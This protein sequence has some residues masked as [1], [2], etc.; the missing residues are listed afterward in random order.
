L[1]CLLRFLPE[2]ALP[3]VAAP[4]EGE[5]DDRP[6]LVSGRGLVEHVKQHASVR[7]A[8]PEGAQ[9]ETEGVSDEAGERRL[10]EL[11]DLGR[12]G[13]RYRWERGVV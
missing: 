10:R 9:R 1:A 12:Q 11:R 7:A 3:K 13:D 8:V 6:R 5:F 4:F 2:L